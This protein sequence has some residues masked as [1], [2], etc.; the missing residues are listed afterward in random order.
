MEEVADGFLKI[1]ARGVLAIVRVVIWI[2]WE[3][4]YERVAWY[5]G[6]PVARLVSLN[7]FPKESFIHEDDAHWLTQ[8]IVAMIG[9][10]YPIGLA[11]FLLRYIGY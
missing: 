6:W 5:L 11:F 1:I 3:V 2:S 8:L 4:L 10:A 9:I 7:Q